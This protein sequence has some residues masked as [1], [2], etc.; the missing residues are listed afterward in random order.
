VPFAVPLGRFYRYVLLSPG[1]AA[2]ILA[3]MTISPPRQSGQA[4]ASGWLVSVCH[5]DRK[6]PFGYRLN[7]RGDGITARL[8]GSGPA[9]A[10][11]PGPGTTSKGSARP[12]ST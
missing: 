5:P 2:T 7:V 11:A 10:P 6:K 9:T 1:R 4:V 3:E 12:C 8:D